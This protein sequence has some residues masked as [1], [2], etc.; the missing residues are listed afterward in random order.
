MGEFQREV[1][2][3]FALLLLLLLMGKDF[4]LTLRFSP[5]KKVAVEALKLLCSSFSQGWLC[6]NDSIPL[7]FLGVYFR[8]ELDSTI[9]D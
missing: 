1:Y 7:I 3:F 5:D 4:S 9:N 6:A 2:R 8:K